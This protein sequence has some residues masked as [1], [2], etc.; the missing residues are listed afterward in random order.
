METVDV[1]KF[2]FDLRN[3]VLYYRRAKHG[4]EEKWEPKTSGLPPFLFRNVKEQVAKRVGALKRKTYKAVSAAILEGL[5]EAG[6]ICHFKVK[7]DSS[8]GDLVWLCNG[9]RFVVFLIC[10]R[11]EHLGYRKDV[12]LLEGLR[13]DD[14][15]VGH[16]FRKMQRKSRALLR[17]A[18]N[19]GKG[20]YCRMLPAKLRED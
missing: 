11:T 1:S 13:H 6:E 7:R 8:Y 3:R 18:W 5:M 20:G 14:T 19:V 17:I 4:S 2:R 9:H 10:D 16:R 12:E 15:K